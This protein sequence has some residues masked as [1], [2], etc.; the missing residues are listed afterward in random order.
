MPM[1]LSAHWAFV[2][3]LHRVS[4]CVKQESTA[5]NVVWWSKQEVMSQ[6]RP[7]AEVLVLHRL[8]TSPQLCKPPKT[9][10][11]L[12]V[13]SYKWCH[14]K[15]KNQ[16]FWHFCPPSHLSPLRCLVILGK[17]FWSLPLRAITP[18]SLPMDR[19]ALARRTPWWEQRWER[20]CVCGWQLFATST[21][22]RTSV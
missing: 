5:Q 13:W 11:R 17:L 2:I 12:D 15:K 22:P 9:K 4:F 14:T 19:P 1:A 8:A 10:L 7:T 3:L 21:V 6:L 16:W 18:V 20:M